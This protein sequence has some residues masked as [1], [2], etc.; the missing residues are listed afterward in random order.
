M[1]TGPP[2]SDGGPPPDSGAFF[3]NYL[4][5]SRI[6]LSNTSNNSAP[7]G[8]TVRIPVDHQALIAAGYAQRSG[9]D[10]AIVL[11][12]TPLPFQ[13][14]D[15]LTVDHQ[16]LVLVTAIPQPIPPGVFSGTLFLYSG[17]PSITTTST[18][19]S[20]YLLAE[21]FGGGIPANWASHWGPTRCFSR[22]PTVSQ[23]PNG[24]AC[25][26]ESA[27]MVGQLDK[28]TL[29]SPAAQ[30]VLATPPP[31]VIYE[32]RFWT[33]G[34]MVNPTDILYLAYGMPGTCTGTDA[35]FTCDPV[36]T[37]VFQ[38]S[39]YGGLVPNSTQ[40]FLENNNANRTVL[41]W[42]F[43]PFDPMHLTDQNWA[44]ATVRFVPAYATP[45]LHFR[46][47]SH[48]PLAA[49]PVSPAQFSLIGIDDFSVRQAFD[50]EIQAAL[51][52]VEAR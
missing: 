15:V 36:N 35:T 26:S 8:T 34:W 45:Q 37:T 41:G 21:R 16:D 14:E 9:K 5:R 23:Q 30:G 10:L 29:V 7:A 3:G 11:D 39:A 1:D 17:D 2:P 43:P 22:T 40:T 44:W 38:A 46:F 20:V 31:G 28:R 42:T 49:P 12:D 48:G 52:P 19:D 32:L 18:T 50:P 25:T 24:S 4:A 6:V 13:F 33:S 47:V 51:G 27:N